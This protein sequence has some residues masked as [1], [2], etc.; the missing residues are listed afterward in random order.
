MTNKFNIFHL[1]EE[2]MYQLIFKISSKSIKSLFLKLIVSLIFISVVIGCSVDDPS[3]IS[4]RTTP[5]STITV[6]SDDFSDGESLSVIHYGTNLTNTIFAKTNGALNI[7][8]HLSWTKTNDDVKSFIVIM[9]ETNASFT[10]LISANPTLYWFRTGITNNKLS[11][12]VGSSNQ[13]NNQGLTTFAQ[14]GYSNKMYFGPQPAIG[15]ASNNYDFV[16][17]GIDSNLDISGMDD[18][19]L[20]SIESQILNIYN[21]YKVGNA[22]VKLIFMISGKSVSFFQVL[23]IGKITAIAKP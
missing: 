15:S 10:S 4:P 11:Q 8:P 1:F 16:V 22:F 2:K 13:A 20:V 19:T 5:L 12:G 3:S 7:S 21:D 14:I 9:I 23:S 6:T 17:F 18:D